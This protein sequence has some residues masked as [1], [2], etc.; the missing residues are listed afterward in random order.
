MPIRVVS[1]GARNTSAGLAVDGIPVRSLLAP[2]NYRIVT[3]DSVPWEGGSYSW[4][5]VTDVKAGLRIIRLSQDNSSKSAPSSPLTMR[6]VLLSQP[7]AQPNGP[8]T[9]TRSV[10]MPEGTDIA[11]A[12]AEPLSSKSATQGDHVKMVVDEMSLSATNS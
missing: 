9:I 11:V 7:S 6:S 10:I 4:D 1:T 2:G 3:P 5:M 12:L 8:A